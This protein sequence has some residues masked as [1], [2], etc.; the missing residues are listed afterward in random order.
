VHDDAIPAVVLRAVVPVVTVVAGATVD[1]VHDIETSSL[2][3]QLWVPHPLCAQLPRELSFP[4][5]PRSS[6][7]IWPVPAP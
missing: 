2:W 7:Q 6:S 1:N 5:Q 4:M 3:T